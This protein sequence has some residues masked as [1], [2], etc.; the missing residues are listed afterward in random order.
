MIA[1][2]QDHRRLNTSVESKSAEDAEL[3][4]YQL[5]IRYENCF[6][7]TGLTRHPEGLATLRDSP[8]RSSRSA[9]SET[10]RVPSP[11]SWVAST[12]LFSWVAS[13]PSLSC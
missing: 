13:T 10:Y 3:F 6:T 1:I 11:F 8:L 5:N 9:L 12:S 2:E 4:D 7:I